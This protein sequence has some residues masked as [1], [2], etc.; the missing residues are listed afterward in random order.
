MLLFHVPF[1]SGTELPSLPYK[2][3]YPWTSHETIGAICKIKLKH[4]A[5]IY[6]GIH[7]ASK[8]LSMH[9]D[10]TTVDET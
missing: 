7:S 2:F 4:L 9:E 3:H 10:N 1:K 6:T 8:H 5:G